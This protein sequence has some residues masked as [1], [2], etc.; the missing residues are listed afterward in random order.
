MSRRSAPV[1]AS[2][3]P[4]RPIPRGAKVQVLRR[5]PLRRQSRSRPTGQRDDCLSS[6]SGVSLATRGAPAF[7]AFRVSRWM[8]ITAPRKPG[9]RTVASRAWAA[10]QHLGVA[11]PLT[12]RRSQ[13]GTNR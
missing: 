1:P 6:N 3:A 4:E 11:A 5:L 13:S 9:S 2:V 10:A 12:P 7:R 8:R